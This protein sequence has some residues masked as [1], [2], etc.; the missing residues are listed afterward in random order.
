MMRV[1]VTFLIEEGKASSYARKSAIMPNIVTLMSCKI[2]EGKGGGLEAGDLRGV[3]KQR[4]P[5][6]WFHL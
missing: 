4:P 1:S 3:L 5:V 6:L 2:G